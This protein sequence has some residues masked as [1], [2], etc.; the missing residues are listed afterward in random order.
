MT[1]LP[2]SIDAS[3]LRRAG[4]IADCGDSVLRPGPKRQARKTTPIL[5][6]A[7]LALTMLAAPVHSAEAE[8]ICYYTGISNQYL[9]YLFVC[10][11]PSMVIWL[12]NP[13]GEGANWQVHP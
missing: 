11:Y 13:S 10:L 3:G 9:G 2:T 8:P 7:A 4:E 6:A 12:G 5:A 1:H